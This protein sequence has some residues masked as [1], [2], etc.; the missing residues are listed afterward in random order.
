MGSEERR[1]HTLG[2]LDLERWEDAEPHHLDLILD[3]CN[4]YFAHNPYNGWFKALDNLISGTQASYYD[5]SNH[6]CHLDLIPY[7]TACKW[8]GLTTH[9]RAA[10]LDS[11]GDTLGLLLKKSSV[12]LLILNGQ[13]VVEN[14]ERIAEIELDKMEMPQWTLP[15]RSSQGVIGYA[16]LGSVTTLAGI[17]LRKAVTVLGFNHNIQS[18]FGV[19]KGV[20][21]SIGHWITQAAEDHV[22]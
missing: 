21:N 10:L 22:I 14:F 9:Q 15:R 7:A 4:N 17:R 11:V 20:K 13:T 5:H 2:S 19:T 3:S 16:Y 6:A 1:F 8:T 12:K 18:S